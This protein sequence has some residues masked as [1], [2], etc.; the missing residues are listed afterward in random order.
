MPDSPVKPDSVSVTSSTGRCVGLAST[1]LLTADDARSQVPAGSLNATAFSQGG[2]PDAA[3][4]SIAMP[5]YLP[6]I[7]DREY[8]LLRS[9]STAT[10]RACRE[11]EE[12]G[13]K[14]RS[15]TD[16][17]ERQG[18]DGSVVHAV[19][20]PPSPTAFASE[21]VDERVFSHGGEVPH[22]AQSEAAHLGLHVGG[23]GK[24]VDGVGCEEGTN[25]FWNSGR[26]VCAA[27]PRRDE[28][29]ELGLRH[30]D[31]R[32][33]VRG[34]RVQQ[35]GDDSG[36]ASVQPFEAIQPDIGRAEFRP[37]DAV[38]DPL[39]GRE[40]LPEDPPSPLDR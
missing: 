1:R 33:Q 22:R 32:L 6:F 2:Q 34:H 21:P 35:G 25:V 3:H 19:A 12:N 23:N 13:S 38:A 9:V 7:S 26:S 11:E 18:H 27:R 29:R 40:H 20:E 15:T 28:G 5:T 17:S 4:R 16:S 8:A 10:K 31:A 39:Q 36:L 37:L 24:Q 14:A 30:A